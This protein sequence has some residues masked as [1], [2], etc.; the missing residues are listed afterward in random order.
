MGRFKGYSKCSHTNAKV[1]GCTITCAGKSGNCSIQNYI[2]IA[3]QM[4]QVNHCS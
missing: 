3:Y 1:Y 2:M 4:E